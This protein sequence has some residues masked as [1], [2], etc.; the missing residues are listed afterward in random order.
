MAKLARLEKAGQPQILPI[1]IA[2]YSTLQQIDALKNKTFLISQK[3][4][5]GA[6]LLLI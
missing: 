5:Y 3:K 6:F 4:K 1:P 2:L